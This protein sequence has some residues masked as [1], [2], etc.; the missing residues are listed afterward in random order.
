MICAEDII[1]EK[2]HILISI[3]GDATVRSAL[4]IMVKDKIGAILVCEQGRYVGIW[5][6]RDLM[7]NVLSHRF[8]PRTAKI[9]DYMITGLHYAPHTASVEL[10][11]DIF[12]GLNIR[13]LLI[14]KK[15]R[16]IGLLSPEDVIM[17]YLRDC[18]KSRVAPAHPLDR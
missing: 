9:R 18:R 13:H 16:Y 11:M 4:E 17:R 5:T 1:K 10:L 14:E 7:R 8:D 3:D 15:G 12:V 6:E 2:G